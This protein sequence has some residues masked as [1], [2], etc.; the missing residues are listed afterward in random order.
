MPAQAKPATP[1]RVLPALAAIGCWL[2]GACGGSESPVAEVAGRAV[3]SVAA[4]GADSLWNAEPVDN[5][6]LITIDTLRWDALGYAGVQPV[7]TPA[8]DALA[9][10]GWIFDNAHA[11]SVVTLP[12]HTNILSGRY[13][14]EHGVRENSGFVFPPQMDSAATLLRDAGFTCGA[15]VGAF[16][17]S[18]RYGLDRGFDLYDDEYSQGWSADFE[19]PERPGDAVV[20][21]ALDWWDANQGRRRF[22]WAHLYDPHAPYAP[23]EP[24][25]SQN[26]GAPYLGE[27]AATD[28]YLA[29]LLDRVRDA[30][31]GR[32][33]VVLTADHGEA[34]GD[35]GELTHGFFVYESTLRVPLVLSAPELEPKRWGHLVR[36]VDILPTL[37]E[38]AGVSEPQGLPGVSLWRPPAAR[39]QRTSYMEALTGNLN[40]GWAPL[41]GMLRGDL[42]LISLP[43]AELYDLGADPGESTNRYPTHRGEAQELVRALPEETPWPPSRGAVTREERDALASLGYLTTTGGSSRVSYG[44]EDDPK[45]LVKI[46]AMLLEVIGAISEGELAAAE[47]KVREALAARPMALGYKLL[48]KIQLATGLRSEAIESFEAAVATGFADMG[49]VRELGRTLTAVG[50]APEA[51]KLLS[52]MRLT[53]DPDGLNA[54]ASA[55]IETGGLAEAESALRQSLALEPRHP[56]TH[57]TLALVA[58]RRED[59]PAVQTAAERALAIDDSMSLAWNYLGGARYNE[60]NTIGALDAWQKSVDFDSSNFDAMYN[61]AVVADA[62]GDTARTRVA[63]RRFIA[64]A[65]PARYGS[66]IREARVWLARIGG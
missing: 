47:I 31:Q 65:P 61:I 25:A 4:A 11:H 49:V 50:R 53:D 3:D 28:A 14:Y 39:E 22:L 36:H 24:W 55:L 8:I 40:R 13:P 6:V 57:E 52:A 27:V 58:L 9:A 7:E 2:L 32:T 41:R 59:W 12:S 10:A 38:A 62:I 35:H 15:V 56:V 51:V 1:R 45:Q 34:L 17:L 20:R 23:P 43:I 64:E 37:L 18:S 46:D 33:L 26:A 63:L 5:V 19:V 48:A 42:K 60:G 29:P 44:P 16:P 30:T 21:R 66:D 54:L